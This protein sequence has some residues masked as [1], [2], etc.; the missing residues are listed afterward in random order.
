MAVVGFACQRQRE[1]VT[2]EMPV[3]PR[4]GRRR[5]G[6]LPSV[7]GDSGGWPTDAP[8]GS[9]KSDNPVCLSWH[10]ATRSS[11][12]LQCRACAPADRPRDSRGSRGAIVPPW[13][14][15][16]ATRGLISPA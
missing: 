11:R 12:R 16:A 14:L 4:A 7:R 10:G 13:L 1:A 2:V 5:D 15:A 3:R 9:G 6:G 8:S